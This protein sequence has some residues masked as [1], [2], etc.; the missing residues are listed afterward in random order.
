MNKTS[1]VIDDVTIYSEQ[2]TIENGYLKV[3]NGKIIEIG[4]YK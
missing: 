2:E 4:T 3:K 1:F